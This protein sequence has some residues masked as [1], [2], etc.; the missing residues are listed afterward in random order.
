MGTGQPTTC[1]AGPWAAGWVA[2]PMPSCGVLG[3]T[4]TPA[5]AHCWGPGQDTHPVPQSAACQTPPNQY[6]KVR[7]LAPSPVLLPLSLC[8]LLPGS[9]AQRA[10]FT[11]P[12]AT[13]PLASMASILPQEMSADTAGSCSRSEL[14]FPLDTGSCWHLSLQG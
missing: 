11:F 7:M 6:K 14:I 12:P 1:Q 5:P 4:H 9:A 2:D 8:K 13:S 3:G 10:P